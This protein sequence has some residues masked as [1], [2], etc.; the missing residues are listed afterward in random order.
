MGN[1]IVLL[2]KALIA[3]EK[4][5]GKIQKV[6]SVYQS[7]AVG[8]QG[9]DFY[10]I[11]IALD[12]FYPPDEVLE[13]CLSVEKFLGRKQ[14]N[15]AVSYEN[16]PIDIDI[17]F[18]ENIV[19]KT[20]HIILPHPRS[21]QRKFVLVPLCEIAPDVLFADTQKNIRFWLER[22]SDKSSVQ[23]KGMLVKDII[24]YFW[25]FLGVNIYLSKS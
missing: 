3:L 9:F 19:L 23:N 17:I 24:F 22:C 2:Q 18:C 10:N 5:I 13:K 8:F 1:R 4:N 7:P 6:S 20:E 11:C 12:S 14:K 25:V 15:K 16:R 21:L